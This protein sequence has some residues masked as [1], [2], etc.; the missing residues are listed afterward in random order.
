MCFTSATIP[1]SNSLFTREQNLH[2]NKT[3]LNEE[4]EDKRTPGEGGEGP[5]ENSSR[6]IKGEGGDYTC[7]R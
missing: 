7:E 1:S 3:K 2:K 6:G 4:Q 5:K